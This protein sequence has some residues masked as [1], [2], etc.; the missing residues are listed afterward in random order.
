MIVA[1]NQMMKGNKYALQLA[2]RVLSNPESDKIW[3]T[4]AFKKELRLA[5]KKHEN[6]DW[7]PD[8]TNE[9]D[10]TEKEKGTQED[11]GV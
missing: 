11:Q 5:L 4:I 8:S 1:F 6:P 9:G 3:G 7:K 2:S 10:S